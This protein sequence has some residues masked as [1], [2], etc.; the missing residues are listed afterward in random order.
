[1]HSQPGPEC[2]G[3]RRNESTNCTECLAGLADLDNEC[4]TC[5]GAESIQCEEGQQ[6]CSVS[7]HGV[8]RMTA[9]QV[10]FETGCRLG[11]S[12]SLHS[13]IPML[14]P[15]ACVESVYLTVIW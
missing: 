6:D 12:P 1:M 15:P 4:S 14:T 13:S 8:S 10:L 2:P 7:A 9:K 5:E 11:A 3:T